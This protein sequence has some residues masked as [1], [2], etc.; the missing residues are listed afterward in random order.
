MWGGG[1]GCVRGGTVLLLSGCVTEEVKDW[2]WGHRVVR[3]VVR[4]QRGCTS[5]ACLMAF[6]QAVSGS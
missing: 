1:R 6:R 4:V 5:H 3:E 2:G